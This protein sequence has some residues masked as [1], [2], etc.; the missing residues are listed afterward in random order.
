MPKV[1]G[2]FD[3]FKNLDKIP[4][5]S[6]T[7][8]NYLANRI[9]YPQAVPVTLIEQ[10]QTLKILLEALKFN[11]IFYKVNQ[12]K[13]FIPEIFLTVADIK[14]IVLLFIEAYSPKGEV[15]FV[16]TKSNGD[17]VLGSLIIVDCD[18]EDDILLFEVDGKNFQV[19]PGNLTILPCQGAQCHV[20][21]SAKHAKILDKND[22]IFEI[23]GGSLGLVIDGRT[24]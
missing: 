3:I 2:I 24:V 15:T 1:T 23:P 16:L 11:Q 9:I 20:K 18:G 17:E 14:K 12:K 8:E 13:I 4:L 6:P 22:S 5:E 21:F 19:K 10:K 7:D